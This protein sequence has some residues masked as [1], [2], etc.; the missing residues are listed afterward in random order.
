MT[1][2]PLAHVV[3]KAALATALTVG[4]LGFSPMTG[5]A[6]T[7]TPSVTQQGIQLADYTDNPYSYDSSGGYDSSEGGTVTFDDGWGGSFDVTDPLQGSDGTIYS[8]NSD[9][10]LGTNGYEDTSS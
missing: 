5:N 10:Y 2:K 3:T 9:Y 7:V 6:Q 1:Y 8:S 4:I